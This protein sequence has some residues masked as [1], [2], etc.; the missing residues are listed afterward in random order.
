M[1]VVMIT[2]SKRGGMVHYIAQL[3][4]SLVDV[5]DVTLIV[6]EGCITNYFDTKIHLK[7]VDIPPQGEWLSKDHFNILKLFNIIKEVNPDIIHISG[8][9]VWVIGLFFFLKVN[10]YP[11]VVTLHDINIHK[12]EDKLVSRIT[13]YFYTK[14]ADCIFVHG[15][16]LKKELLKKGFDI[17]NVKVI[18]HGDY[19]FFTECNKNNI[20][21]DGSILFFGRIEDYKGLKYL[22]KAIPLISEEVSDVNVIVA[23]QGNL[24]KYDILI[25]D[26][27]NIE[28]I[29]EYI[30]DD[31][32]NELFQRASIVVMPYIEG[33][34]S[35]II[36]I[37]YSFK[38]PVVV[39]DV[40]SIPE[41]VDDGITG[42]IVPPMNEKALA[43]A[44]VTII[45]NNDLKKQMG[46]NGYKKMKKELS[47]DN[48]SKQ[49]I[50]IYK[51]INNDQHANN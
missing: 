49:T 16:N 47:W 25:K 4:N 36:P 28:I 3:A 7:T 45:S 51:Q 21:E 23:G 10:K 12:G 8:S 17:N 46:E 31:L 39:T 41:V 22:L 30:E 15:E 18:K 40:G 24:N 35:G 37:A 13:N 11:V 19:S 34:Q 5:T 33:S 29:N 42:F 14:I 1:K 26:Q 6:P 20:K 9:Y 50:E 27:S 38:K 2:L 43:K 32:V 44:I 48:I